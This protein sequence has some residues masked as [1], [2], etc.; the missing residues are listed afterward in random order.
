M[1]CLAEDADGE[2]AEGGHGVRC[3]AGAD[4]GCVFAVAS[5]D[6]MQAVFDGP[7]AAEEVVGWAPGMWQVR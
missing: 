3:G 4:T 7:V 2:V 1:A 6:P 5:R